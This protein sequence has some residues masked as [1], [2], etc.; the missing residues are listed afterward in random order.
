M[1][2]LNPTQR[3]AVEQL[4]TLTDGSCDADTTI[5]VL[6]SVDWDIEKA[7]NVLFGDHETSSFAR[8]NITADDN[9]SARIDVVDDD[10]EDEDESRPLTGSG[11][12]RGA[13][14]NSTVSHL[15]RPSMLFSL[16]AFPFNLISGILRTLYMLL[17]LP[18]GLAPTRFSSLTFLRGFSAASPKSVDP[19]SA[20]DR[21]VRALEEE[22]GATCI[23]RAGLL[24]SAV[25]DLEA[26]AQDGKKV[27]PD[28]VVSSYEEALRRCEREARIGCV[29][30]VSEE[31]DDVAE[32][33]RT[34]LTDPKFVHLL[35]SN[36]FV[37]WGGDVRDPD[38]WSASQKLQATTFPFVAFV[39]LQ[40]RRTT[41]SSTTTA[42]SPA[43]SLTVLSRHQ[44]H[45]ATAPAKLLSHLDSQLLPRVTP[46]LERTRQTRARQ[47]RDRAL[48]AEQER[49]FAEAAR[50][51]AE[52]L[53]ARM[54]EER[55]K[56]EE[57]R[58]RMEEREAEAFRREK[59]EAVRRR[60][61][62][63]VRKLVDPVKDGVRVAVRSP[64]GARK[65]VVLDP[66]A[67]LTVLYAYVDA[68][69]LM[70]GVDTDARSYSGEDAFGETDVREQIDLLGGDPDKW[71]GF[72]LA[73]TY[74]RREIEWLPDRSI[75]DVEGLKGGAQ[76]VV[77]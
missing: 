77:E 68:E 17:R 21:W 34:T 18:F 35:H 16:L 75:A 48:R 30:L 5:S 20:A 13:Q 12:R 67:S 15:P 54:E 55:R 47:D 73:L 45:A 52:R 32:F 31:H 38:T 53:Q 41:G 25:E 33:K 1:N 43:L 7:A 39:A 44:G 36:N 72:K 59:R 29:V 23:S 51:D 71:W 56:R 22:T 74:P 6:E 49:A 76:L 3:S 63:W 40:P 64:S 2:N 66:A 14:S 42:S 69:V 58:R 62:R 24:G 27:L 8:N 57:E 9:A 10:D 26:A 37:V 11:R 65:V 70:G 19:Q 4:Q 61:R 60:Q 50:R 28:F 46:V